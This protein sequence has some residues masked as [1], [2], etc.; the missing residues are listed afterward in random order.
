MA[1]STKTSTEAGRGRWI[2]RNLGALL[3][4]HCDLIEALIL[5]EPLF[6]MSGSSC[7]ASPWSPRSPVR[8][9][10]E[11]QSPEDSQAGGKE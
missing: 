5:L 6:Q 2:L 9:L 8:T 1:S 7:L 4:W 3:G 10:D 11:G